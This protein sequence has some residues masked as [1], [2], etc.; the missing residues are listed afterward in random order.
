MFGEVGEARRRRSGFLA[1][2]R[3]CAFSGALHEMD[4][5]SRTPSDASAEPVVFEPAGGRLPRVAL[6]PAFFALS[7]IYV[8]LWVDTRLL[9]YRLA[10]PFPHFWLSWPYAREFLGRPGGPME[11]AR[12]FLVQLFY[13]PWAGALV[14][15]A[16]AALLCAGAWALSR[17]TGGRRPSIACLA[18]AVGV[19]MLYSAY[20]E[21]LRVCL[22]VLVAVVGA[23]AAVRA[24]VRGPGARAVWFVGVSVC[25]YYLS[26]GGYLLF[27]VLC[28]LHELLS[29]RTALALAS[30]AWGAAL[31][32]ALGGWV[33]GARL[34]D[35]YLWNLPFDR[36]AERAG[37]AVAAGLCLFFPL[38]ALASRAWQWFAARRGRPVLG[39]R[40]VLESLGLLVVAVP[41]VGFSID[42][43]LRNWLRVESAARRGEWQ[44][45]LTAARALPRRRY[46]ALVNETVNW[47]LCRTGRLPYE[48]LKYPQG[49]HGLLC[50]AEDF[51]PPMRGEYTG[52]PPLVFMRLSDVYLDLGRVNE[53]EQMAGEA[54]EGQGYRPWIV[55]RLALVNIVK[56]RTEAARVYLHLL[57]EDIVYGRRARAL[58]ERLGQDPLLSSDEQVARLR[59]LRP[60]YEE[61]AERNVADLLGGLL[62]ADRGNR[63]AFEYLMAHYL[64][65]GDLR[66]V[67]ANLRRLRE[68]GYGDVPRYYEEAAALYEAFGGADAGLNV[69]AVSRETRARLAKF[70]ERF[71]ALSAEGTG[72][73]GA[74]ARE[75]PDSYFEYYILYAAAQQDR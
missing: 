51:V 49:P 7:F 25:V 13:W 23:W 56:G 67:V 37:A 42:G 14:V 63:M 3:A 12:A 24:P 9:Y 74:L 38:A 50:R 15:T 36:H 68:L 6:A 61:R 64:L 75:F 59:A 5:T 10:P 11:Y 53:A 60:V 26:G 27:A 43:E 8:L 48:L 32:L 46:D 62:R 52:P 39:R 30:A 65:A 47:A 29:G 28:A 41:A 33:L 20:A 54:L 19:L 34:S 2:R 55:E 31:P 40:L 16:V 1:R 73:R 44:G 57:S 71:Q 17:A 69:G 70:L 66:D 45:V 21:H 4:A 22:A 72:A 58:L 18:P 35:A